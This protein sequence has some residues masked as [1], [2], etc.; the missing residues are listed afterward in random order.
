[1]ITFQKIT[2]AITLA[3]FIILILF[4]AYPFDE[5]F[6]ADFFLRLDPLAAVG[7]MIAS[8]TFMLYLLPGLAVLAASL[9]LGRFFCGHI[10]PMGTMLDILQG[11]TRR[12]KIRAKNR[13][14]EGSAQFRSWKYLG[15][16]FIL[17]SAIGGVSL[18]FLGSPL[19]LITRLFAL[20]L[21]PV[22]LLL[23][24]LG[25]QASAPLAA[26]LGFSS[27]LYSELT[28][29][30]FATNYFVFCLFAV[31]L[32]LS[33]VQPRFWCR[34]VCPAGALMGLFSRHALLKRQVSDSCSGCG[35]CIGKCPVSAIS[36]SPKRTVHSECIVC[37]RC[38]EICPESAIAFSRTT[39]VPDETLRAPDPTRRGILLG[40]GSGLFSA[41]LLQTSVDQP[42]TLRRERTLVD[43]E[44]IRPPGAV[45][46]PDFLNRC[47]RC[48]E[49]MKA[50]PTNTLQPVWL[51]AGLEGIFSPV[52]IPRLAGCATN[53]NVCG[54][55]CPTGAIRNL[56]L[57]EKNHAKIGTASVIRHSCLAWEQ[58][59]K[60]LV[61]DEV[62][63]Y[64]ALSFRPVPGLRNPVPFVLANRCTGCGWCESKCPVNGSS[65]IR[66]NVIGELRLSGGSYVDKAR[67][68]GFVFKTKD[69]SHDLIA[70]GTFDAPGGIENDP[71]QG[72]PESP[73]MGLPPGFSPK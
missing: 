42:N 41:G 36:E 73:T 18:V 68:H 67:E 29:R 2:Q 11:L 64:N 66:V 61:C 71:F 31:I 33:Y 55:V 28:P 70:P 9:M 32:A 34:N 5:G 22:V 13:S 8:R 53:C 16:L 63:P 46:E 59:K 62:C 30:F 56:P 37:M 21:H 60:C 14:Y 58:D 44:L 26:R 50:C 19:S 24:E 51:K 3:V 1:M 49:C 4:A 10:C 7:T 27:L 15:L 52:V 20:V 43:P 54:Q 72:A 69:K 6:P 25:L 35:R 65:A 40:I 38:K 17:A 12:K 39:V 57:I 45:L 23:G 48:G 47:I